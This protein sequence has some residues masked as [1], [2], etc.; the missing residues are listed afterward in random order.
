MA[1]T[2]ATLKR[3]QRNNSLRINRT[4]SCLQHRLPGVSAAVLKP[5]PIA[6]E[7]ALLH[8]WF[9][10]EILIYIGQSD[11]CTTKLANCSRTAL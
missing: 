7:T 4:R 5:G 8:A 3:A 1:W 9:C 6:K 11:S 10:L 2:M